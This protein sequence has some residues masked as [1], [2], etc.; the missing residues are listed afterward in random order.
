[1]ADRRADL[2]L[3]VVADDRQALLGEAALPVRL[4]ADEHRDRVDEA[5]AGAE[6]LLH[7]PLRRLLAA[8]R[9]VGDHDV[10]LALLEDPDDVGR[11][12]RAPSR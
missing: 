12:A 9:Q 5:D 1:V 6:R 7:V 8:D 10:D 3:D 2:A 11:R 4:A